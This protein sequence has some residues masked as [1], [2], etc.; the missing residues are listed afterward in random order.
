[1]THLTKDFIRR[2]EFCTQ[3]E[4]SV[5]RPSSHA[6]P[7]DYANH[8]SNPDLCL[9]ESPMNSVNKDEIAQGSNNDVQTHQSSNDSLLDSDDEDIK[10]IVKETLGHSP[11]RVKARFLPLDKLLVLPQLASSVQEG[12]APKSQLPAWP[13]WSENII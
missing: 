6:T 1:M 10:Q 7:P 13:G 5:N 2:Q 9:T 12:Q 3:D 4:N 8:H 11:K